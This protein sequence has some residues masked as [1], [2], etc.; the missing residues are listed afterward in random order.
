MWFFCFKQKTAYEMRISDGSSDVCSSDLSQA[1]HEIPGGASSP[2][3]CPA[4]GGLYVGRL[5]WHALMT[6]P[7]S[8]AAVRDRLK[9]AGH[10]TLFL[11]YRVPVRR[12]NRM[13]RRQREAVAV[14]D[15]HD[16][17]LLR[18]CLPRYVFIRLTPADDFYTVA[19]LQG[20]AVFVS[21]EAGTG[22]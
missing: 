12:L 22:E 8:E 19:T 11:H 2:G 17:I 10:E 18:P 5:C 21:S 13:S 20:V 14:D 3:A 9:A 1:R 16:E 6:Q 15:K 4:C 7:R